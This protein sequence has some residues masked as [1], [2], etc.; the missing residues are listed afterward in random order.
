M[1]R[2]D[3]EVHVR[4]VLTPAA[5]RLWRD[6]ET[7]QL[8][9]TEGRAVVLAG[10]D[11][12]ARAVLPLLD[13][14]RDL[15]EVER[16][17]RRAGC[18][19]ERT[20]ELLLLLRAAGLVVD[21]AE[22]WP[23]RLDV[24]ERDRLA[25]D[26]ASLC[27]L[28]AG[29]GLAALRRRDRAAVLVLGAGRVGVPLAALLAAAGVGTVDVHDEGTARPSDVAVGGLGPDDVGRR[30]GEAA[31]RRL[32]RVSGSLRSGP[33]PRPDLAVLA[34]AGIPDEEQ[35]RALHRAGVPHLVAEV[36]ES[37]G[38]VGP[39]VLP[40]RS[41]CLRCLDLTRADLDPD[42]PALAVQLSTPAPGPLP[43]DGVLAAGVSAQAALQVLALLDGAPTASVDGTLELVL[44]DWRWRR[45]SWA[46]HDACPCRWEATG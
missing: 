13:G 12:A 25:P 23:E 32:R 39:L 33:L 10:L 30:R 34:P 16:A 45:R 24:A 20:G 22:R 2:T 44:P 15:D 11:V 19:P 7:L 42:W 46:R 4:P 37:V 36:R 31:R 41:A 8:G 21:A 5:R 40:G 28:H 9:R 35:A 14:T 6:R 18:P 1:P 3:L 27:Q 29:A 26:V 43:C 17:A 38:V